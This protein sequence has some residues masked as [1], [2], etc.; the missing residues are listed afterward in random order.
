MS[1][2]IK[3][4]RISGIPIAVHPS[5]LIAFFFIAWT[6]SDLFQNSFDSWSASQYWTGAIIG[7]LALFASVL[8][9]ELAHS[10]VAQRL[11][12]PVQ[13]ITLFIFGGV[14]Q[15][16]GRYKRARDEF[17]VAFAGPLSSL[18]IGAV[19]LF[20]WFT[21]RPDGGEDPSLLLGIIF[22]LGAMN[23]ILGVFNLLPG[24]PLDGG[25]VLRSAVWGWSGSE[26]RATRVAAGV[27]NIVAWILMAIGIF[28]FLNG[29]IIGGIWL[30]FIGLFLQSA[31]RGERR[32]ESVRNATQVPLRAAVQ[33]TPQMV[34]ATDRVS[35]VMID[36]ISRGFQQVV[37]VIERDAPI[38]F[39]TA[40]DANRF[41]PTEWHNLSVGGVIAR[42]EPFTVQLSDDAFDVLQAMQARGLRYALVLAMDNVVGVV[43]QAELEALIRYRSADGDASVGQP[44]YRP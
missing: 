29:N 32:A 9:H 36:V 30:A 19:G 3:I 7:S 20:V 28:Q 8:V 10:I 34:D 21:L 38:G 2:S 35:D 5:W 23:I 6:I 15:I 1:S 27:G 16:Q 26:S 14:S 18:I 13:G 42:Q 41:P 33:R 17:L 39:F 40:E 31:A 12:L 37:P 44:P 4:G 11:G 22:Y 24:F 25:R 43:G